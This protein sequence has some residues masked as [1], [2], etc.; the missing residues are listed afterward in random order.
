[1]LKYKASIQVGRI[2]PDLLVMYR[3]WI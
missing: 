1:M 2:I 3:L